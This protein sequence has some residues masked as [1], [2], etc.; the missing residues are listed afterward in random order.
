[1]STA[2]ISPYGGLDDTSGA[3]RGEAQVFQG[4]CSQD[5]VSVSLTTSFPADGSPQ[6]VVSAE[7]GYIAVYLSAPGQIYAGPE[8]T[9]K[10]ERG[11]YYPPG[12][13]PMAVKTGDLVFIRD[14]A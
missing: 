10:E 12:W 13:W 6:L 5:A 4:E 7:T 8:A 14:L 3:Y 9:L 2:Y 11:G 1:M